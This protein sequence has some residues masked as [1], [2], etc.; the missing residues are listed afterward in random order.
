MIVDAFDEMLLQSADQPLV[1]GVALHP[2][3]VGQPHRLRRLRGALAHIA[4]QRESIW[5][6]RAGEI[7]RY[8]RRKCRWGTTGAQERH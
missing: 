3:I 6:T 2:Y 5:L 1:M 8:L 4:G 7:S